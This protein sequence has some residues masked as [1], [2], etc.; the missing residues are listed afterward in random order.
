VRVSCAEEKAGSRSSPRISRRGIAQPFVTGDVVEL[1]ADG[2]FTHLGRADGIVKIAGR[3]VSLQEMEDGLRRLPDVADAAVVAIPADAGRGHQLLAAV[4]PADC[5]LAGAR[6]ALL[7]RFDPSS[8]PRR[9]VAVEAIP[10]EENGKLQRAA[11]CAFSVSVRRGDRS[12]RR[13]R[14]APSRSSR[15]R[16]RRARAARSGFPSAGTR[17]RGISTGIRCSPARCS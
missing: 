12:G 8:L 14:S 9:V 2:R 16:A 10:R 6:S 4:A 7:E 3:R 5:D 15:S 11:S 13:S 17:S 1:H